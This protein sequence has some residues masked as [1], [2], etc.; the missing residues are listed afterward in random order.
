[1]GGRTCGW[2]LPWSVGAVV[3]CIGRR[4][5]E[6]LQLYQEGLVNTGSTLAARPEL[7]E[8]C[9]HQAD[10][11]LD[12]LIAEL[13]RR[14]DVVDAS[15][16]GLSRAIG[17]A[18]AAGN[19]H[20]TESLDAS[21]I[22]F[23][24]AVAVLDEEVTAGRIDSHAALDATW[25]LQREIMRRIRQA[26]VAYAGLLLGKV[27]EAQQVE[28]R[29]I[30]RDLHDRVGT[31]LSTAH[32]ALEFYQ[33][34]EDQPATA[35][36]QVQIADQSIRECLAE[37]RR[38]TVGLRS[39]NADGNRPL[40]TALRRFVEESGSAIPVELDVNGDETWISPEVADEL[41]LVVREAM[42][43]ALAHSGAG[44]VSVR[45][46]IAPHEVRAQV[47]DDGIGF[48]QDER[49]SGSGLLAMQERVALLD[50]K[51]VILTG[52]GRGT[53]I[54]VVVPLSGLNAPDGPD[55]SD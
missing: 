7:L 13:S 3:E 19:I 30:A 18:R 1:M 40:E 20:P 6:I 42:R 34:H 32:F 14:R 15:D 5:S 44:S 39:T 4:R 29:R 24:S 10:L 27:Q 35:R 25:H 11:I 51:M 53:G 50:G 45:V 48:H 33:D 38:M 23:T 36:R 47:V 17:K 22:F 2:C 9:R 28:R 55:E 16:I 37:L 26:S 31:G 8:E 49:G 43:N 12:S 52:R 46:D 41:F 21:T 54:E